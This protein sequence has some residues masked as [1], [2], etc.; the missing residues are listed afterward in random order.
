MIKICD[1]IIDE[2]TKGRQI[3]DQRATARAI[4]LNRGKILLAYSKKY[5]DYMTPGGGVANE[6]Y[7]D[8]LY[9]EL[10]EEMGVMV[11]NVRPIGYI[12]EIR[13]NENGRVLYQKSHY[14]FTEI[15]GHVEKRLE[16]YEL[17]FGLEPAWVHIEDV[18]KHNEA[19]IE[20][21]IINGINGVHPFSTL[22][23]ENEILKYILKEQQHEK[24]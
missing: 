18:I 14:F 4:I 10:V 17:D 3:D 8:A 21:R 7:E 22:R 1:T 19:I 2:N 11:K 16:T 13:L 12:D 20:K 9:R 23:R 24:I 15:D 5:D 6:S